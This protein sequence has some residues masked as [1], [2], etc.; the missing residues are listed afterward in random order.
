MASKEAEKHS[1]QARWPASIP[2]IAFY[3]QLLVK[4]KETMGRTSMVK[5][6]LLAKKYFLYLPH[7]R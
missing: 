3:H 4:D 1:Q 6:L 7:Q 5:T 2:K